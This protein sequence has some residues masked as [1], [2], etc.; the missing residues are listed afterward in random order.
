MPSPFGVARSSIRLDVAFQPGR[1]LIF[2]ELESRSEQGTD[3]ERGRSRHSHH[4]P[5]AEGE[6]WV[7]RRARA[8]AGSTEVNS[9]IFKMTSAGTVTP[10][11]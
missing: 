2:E 7:P 6:A 8:N 4:V 5:I 3:G 1:F 11:S 9:M 10:P